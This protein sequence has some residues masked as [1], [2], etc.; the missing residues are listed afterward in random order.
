MIELLAAIYE[1]EGWKRA[2]GESRAKRAQEIYAITSEPQRNRYVAT[3]LREELSP[4]QQPGFWPEY[5]D[6]TPLARAIQMPLADPLWQSRVLNAYVSRKQS[7]GQR[8]DATPTPTPDRGVTASVSL[9]TDG[10]ERS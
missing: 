9:S 4:D 6:P 7:L 5:T 1:A 8:A 10:R 2:E 3:P